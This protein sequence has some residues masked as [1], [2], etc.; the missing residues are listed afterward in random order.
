MGMKKKILNPEFFYKK[1]KA[2][3]WE[4]QI[5]VYANKHQEIKIQLRA[6]D[7]VEPGIFKP[8]PLIPGGWIAHPQTI[9]AVRKDIFLGDEDFEE[10]EILYQCI[11]C[12]KTIDLQFWIRC[13]YCDKIIPDHF[14]KIS[15]N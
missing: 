8:D 6:N 10:L 3:N 7:G 13:P 1:L 4:G 9:N 11:G 14:E 2:A 12:K 5:P 15:C